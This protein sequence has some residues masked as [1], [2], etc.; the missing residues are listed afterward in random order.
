[1]QINTRSTSA[2]KLQ[3]KAGLHGML[4]T[5]S[6]ELHVHVNTIASRENNNHLI[7]NIEA[8]DSKLIL[9]LA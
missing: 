3:F 8:I 1:M 6:V 7:I 9:A 2:V 4:S 5:F